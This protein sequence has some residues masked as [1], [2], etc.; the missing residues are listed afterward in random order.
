MTEQEYELVKSRCTY[1][2]HYDFAEVFNNKLNVMVCCSK[3]LHCR[4]FRVDRKN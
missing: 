1:C 4:G 2:G 3:C